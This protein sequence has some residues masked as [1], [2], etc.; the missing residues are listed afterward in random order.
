MTKLATFLEENKID[1]RRVLS[2]SNQI[3]R[4]RAED[5]RIRL[6]QAKARK[7]DDGKK[8]EGLDKPRSGRPI[9]P[10]GLENALEGK[11]VPG[12]QK[13]RILRAVNRILEQKRKDPVG[14]DTLFDVPPQNPAKPKAEEPAEGDGGDEG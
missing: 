11:S 9:T 14:I 4:L 2:A 1:K 13:T 8:P 6:A 5:R 12:P 7:N 3:E 10:V